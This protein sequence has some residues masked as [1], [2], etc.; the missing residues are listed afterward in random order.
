MSAAWRA[1]AFHA[2]EQ[3]R[4]GATRLL[5]SRTLSSI[6]GSVTRSPRFCFLRDRA[7]RRDGCYFAA[8]SMTSVSWRCRA[9]R[10][11]R[12]AGLTPS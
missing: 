2:T 1:L 3:S 7:A 8:V 10:R 12:L 6:E 4:A 5:L 9:S 11:Y